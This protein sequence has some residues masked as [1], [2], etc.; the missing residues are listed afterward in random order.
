MYISR[1]SN[2]IYLHRKKITTLFLLSFF[3]FNV[4]AQKMRGNYNFL[5]F[6]QKPYYFGIT[7]AYNNSDYKLRFSDTFINNDSI[8]LVSSVTGLGFN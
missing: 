7:L 5:D 6:Q 2:L 3:F 1:N 4:S 8:R